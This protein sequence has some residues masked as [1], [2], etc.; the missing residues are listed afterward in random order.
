MI[1]L[2]ERGLR[3]IGNPELELGDIRS[4]VV[5][6]FPAYDPLRPVLPPPEPGPTVPEPQPTSGIQD[7]LRRYGIYIILAIA[8]LSILGSRRIE[9]RGQETAAKRRSPRGEE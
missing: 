5:G 3:M 6:R 1:A 4:R 9:R 8:V 2:T 7:F